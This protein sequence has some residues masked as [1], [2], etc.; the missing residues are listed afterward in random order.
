MSDITREE[1][2][3][4]ADLAKIALTSAELDRLAGQ[5]DAIVDAVAVVSGAVDES[6]PATSHPIELTNVMR[7][8][9]PEPCLTNEESLAAA[10]AAEDGFFRVP[11]LMGETP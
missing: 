8:D 1:V 5:L 7:E 3:R 4:L 2:A 11:R 6:I 9:I 10:P